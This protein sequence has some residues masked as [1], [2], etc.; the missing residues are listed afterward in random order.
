MSTCMFDND[1]EA[2]GYENDTWFGLDEEKKTTNTQWSTNLPRISE[3]LVGNTIDGTIGDPVNI[4]KQVVKNRYVLPI[5]TKMISDS[6]GYL[7][8]S[9]GY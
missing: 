2:P 8:N 1:K 5:T 9:Y 4:A 3:G 6:N 7:T